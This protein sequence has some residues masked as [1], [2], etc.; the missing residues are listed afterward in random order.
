MDVVEE[1]KAEDIVLLDLRP[2]TVIADFFVLANGNSD[3]QLRALTDY[4]RE[5]VKAHHKRL[6]VSIEGTAESGWVLLDYGDVIVHLFSEDQRD[7]YDIE[8]LWSKAGQVILS[9][10]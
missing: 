9:I 7:Y 8:G 3:R 6:P 5:D 2:D 1:R 4:I 10:Q